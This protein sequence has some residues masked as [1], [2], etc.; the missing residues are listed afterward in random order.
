M[1]HEL[2]GQS[3]KS[4]MLAPEDGVIRAV[5]SLVITDQDLP[6]PYLEELGDVEQ[7]WKNDNSHQVVPER[8]RERLSE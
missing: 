6:V 3:L 8:G 5:D 4:G 1:D 7:D 2:L